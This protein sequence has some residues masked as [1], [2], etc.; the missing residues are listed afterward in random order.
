MP[1]FY[2][3]T[4]TEEELIQCLQAAVD[5]HIEAV[6]NWG[7][8]PH[9]QRAIERLQNATIG[10]RGLHRWYDDLMGNPWPLPDNFPTP[11]MPEPDT[12]NLV[13][14]SIARTNKRI[15]GHK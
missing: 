15:R 9:S 12:S 4:Q 13:Y 11:A 10:A 7:R 8:N 1:R 14:D 5:A 2:V 6:I 3:P